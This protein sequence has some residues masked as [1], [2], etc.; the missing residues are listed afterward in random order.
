MKV[1]V[2]KSFIGSDGVAKKGAVIEVS[3]KLGEALIG[4]GKVEASNASTKPAQTITSSTQA[5]SPKPA[6]ETTGEVVADKIEDQV[7]TGDQSHGKDADAD[8]K[9]LDDA[10]TDTADK[11]VVK[12]DDLK[13]DDQQGTVK[14]DT[15]KDDQPSKVV[16]SPSDTVPA[17]TTVVNKND[18]TKKEVK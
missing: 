7:K 11:T 5:P 9:K 4:A 2:L 16:L 6:K 8:G 18:N 12:S 1:V 10:K 15:V 13:I 14:T 3:K 17:E